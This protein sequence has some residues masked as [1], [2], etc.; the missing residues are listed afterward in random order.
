MG[1]G[2]NHSS[3]G[4]SL[5]LVRDEQG[6]KGRP[7]SHLHRSIAVPTRITLFAGQAGA[8]AVMAFSFELLSVKNDPLRPWFLRPTQRLVR[9]GLSLTGNGHCQ[10]TKTKK[11]NGRKVPDRIVAHNV[12][13][14]FFLSF[15]RSDRR[16][17]IPGHSCARKWGILSW[18][19][20]EY[21]YIPES[22]FDGGALHTS[23][24]VRSLWQHPSS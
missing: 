17:A 19:Q 10:K 20:S 9:C 4:D 5:P 21:I 23:V 13:F 24:F 7:E 18:R 14:C 8:G 11:R 3:E 12:P 6:T 15:S 1:K 22:V 16:G 2:T